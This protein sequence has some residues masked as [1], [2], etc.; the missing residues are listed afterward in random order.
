MIL[1]HVTEEEAEKSPIAKM[2]RDALEENFHIL[3]SETDQSGKPLR[4]CLVVDQMWISLKLIDI[5]YT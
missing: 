5:T 1:S 2:S 4:V 3:S